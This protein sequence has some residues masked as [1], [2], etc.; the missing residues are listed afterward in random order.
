VNNNIKF[1]IDLYHIDQSKTMDYNTELV[2]D[3]DTIK[4]VKLSSDK[5]CITQLIEDLEWLAKTVSFS[6]SF[7]DYLLYVNK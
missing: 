2:S 6:K 1:S 3:I 4:Y 5:Y 7:S